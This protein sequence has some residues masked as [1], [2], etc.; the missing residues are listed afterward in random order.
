L[1]PL[2][3][4]VTAN[5]ASGRSYFLEDG[6]PPRIQTVDGR[7]G[8]RSANLWRTEGSP[9]T[10]TAGDSVVEQ[11]GVMPPASGTVLRVID[12]PP[13][14]ADPE[15]RRR[16][17]SASLRALFP[18]A[19]HEPTDTKPG[20]HRTLSVDYAIVLSGTITAI[21]DDGE[22]E[23]HAGDILIQRGTNHAWENRTDRMTRIAFILVDGR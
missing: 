2:R 10:I 19:A 11:Q 5:N 14:P 17:A 1:R 12:Y 7:P 6:P 18:D 22:T 4:V 9:A 15:E 20:M 16:Q 3:R 8:F 13:R 23:L 21:L